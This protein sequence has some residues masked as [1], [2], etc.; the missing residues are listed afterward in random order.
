[1]TLDKGTRP[2]SSIRLTAKAGRR[3]NLSKDQILG[4]LYHAQKNRALQQFDRDKYFL[5][6]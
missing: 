3:A 4:E 1:M 5:S 6:R 2:A